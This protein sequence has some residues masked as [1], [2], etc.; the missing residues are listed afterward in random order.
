MRNYNVVSLL[1]NLYTY[2]FLGGKEVVRDSFFFFFEGY[3]L[4][5]GYHFQADVSLEVVVEQMY[6]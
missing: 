2:T 4:C 6:C 3:V 5:I 1:L